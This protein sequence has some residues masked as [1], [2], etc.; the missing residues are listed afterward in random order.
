MDGT[1]VKSDLDFQQI[2]SEAC[3]PDGTP[4]LELLDLIEGERGVKALHVLLT[5]EE[6]A[7]QTCQLLPGAEEVLREL[8]RRQ[9][10]LALLTRNSRRSVEHVLSR[11]D[12]EFDCSISREEAAPKPSPEPVRTIGSQLNIPPT[13]LLLVGDYLF[14]LQAAKAAGARSA[15]LRTERTEPFVHDADIVLEDLRELPDYIPDQTAPDLTEAV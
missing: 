2:R 5:H 11:F 6:R 7:A 8:R 1:L 14:D 13:N 10:P 15:I 4:D 9:F 3:V 12:L